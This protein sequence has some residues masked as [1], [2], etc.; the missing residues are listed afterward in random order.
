MA[1]LILQDQ[2]PN[3]DLERLHG[4]YIYARNVSRLCMSNSSC[5][6]TGWMAGVTISA[7]N[8]NWLTE[9]LTGYLQNS[10]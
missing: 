6:L 9:Q 2:P 10:S 4:V 3:N 8:Q 7:M 5:I 1:K